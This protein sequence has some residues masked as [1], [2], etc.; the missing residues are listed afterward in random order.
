MYRN[1]LLAI[2]LFL[3]AIGLMMVFSASILQGGRMQADSTF[4]RQLLW[5]SLAFL[6]LW[7]CS[8]I[9]YHRVIR[10]APLILGV[11]VI[12]LVIVLLPHVGQKINNARRWIR[13]FGI[14]IQPSELA[15]L[16]AVIFV[17]WWVTRNRYWVKDLKKVFLPL[18]VVAVVLGGLVV[19][20]PDF[21]TGVLIAAVVV[22]MGVLGGMRVGP[23]I[24]AAAVAM[25]VLYFLVWSSPY[26]R[27]RW[28]AFL[29]PWLYYKDGAGFQLIQ[30][31]IAIGSGGATGLGLG[32]SRQKLGFL[33][34]AI[35]DFIFSILGE[36]L[37]FMGSVLVIG[38]FIAFVWNGMRAARRARDLE[39]FMLISGV[40]MVIGFQ[41]LINLFV[42]T[43]MMPT[44]GISLPFISAGGSSLFFFMCSVGLMLNAVGQCREEEAG[45]L[46]DST[47]PAA[48]DEL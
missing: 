19:M 35:N 16:A 44:K 11:S 28:L 24:P 4:S 17:S 6:G 32:E 43:G 39:G 38:L 37:G 8:K 13:F 23:L 46:E 27:M 20:E 47:M 48:T 29:D 12:L 31:L 3:V 45:L 34:E 1:N 30:S 21:G 36:E 7:L 9:D 40:T 42:V 22:F 41:A 26:R 10:Q 33:P 14:G 18:M 2:V 15:K 5:V 25:P